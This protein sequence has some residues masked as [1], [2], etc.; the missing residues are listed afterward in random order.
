V[1]ASDSDEITCDERRRLAEQA[2]DRAV[3]PLPHD[4]RED[5][6]CVLVHLGTSCFSGCPTSV[7][8]SQREAYERARMEAD[9]AHCSSYEEDGCP[10]FE[11]FCAEQRAVC[12][13]GTC[14][15]RLAQ[16]TTG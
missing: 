14:E 10:R 7:L 8:A 11:R 15:V 4:C 1:A 6:E 2:L 13:R 12:V 16:E 3:S 5:A 9:A